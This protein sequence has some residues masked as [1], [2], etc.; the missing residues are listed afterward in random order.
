MSAS[1]LSKI[2]T[3]GLAVCRVDPGHKARTL[4]EADPPLYHERQDSNQMV[5]FIHLS[6]HE[7]NSATALRRTSKDGRFS[8]WNLESV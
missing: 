6:F 7:L 8:F 2:T 3:R 4:P 1:T 5:S